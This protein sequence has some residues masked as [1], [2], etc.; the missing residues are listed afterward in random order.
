MVKDDTNEWFEFANELRKES[1]FN[2]AIKSYNHIIKGNLS[3]NIS[4]KALLGLAKTFE[5]QIVPSEEDYLIPYF[6]DNNLFFKD[7]FGVYSTI[8]TDNLSSS[9]ALYDS[10]LV[11]LDRSPLI[12]EAF[13]K[14]GEIQYRMLQDFDKAYLLFSKAMK[15][16]PNKKVELNT[17]LRITDAVSYTHL[18][19]PTTL[20]V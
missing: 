7:P 13:F 19:L 8:S 16:K 20:V 6:Y 9:I 11:T 2:Y 17:T 15:N 4:G 5:D 14:L 3:S 10:M 18:T 1:Q 12:A